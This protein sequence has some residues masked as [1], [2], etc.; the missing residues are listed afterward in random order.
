MFPGSFAACVA[1]AP[2]QP[3]GPVPPAGP[4]SSGFALPL[5]ARLSG[6]LPAGRGLLLC[7]RAGGGQTGP[8]APA[9]WSGP[10]SPRRAARPAFPLSARGAS[11]PFGPARRRRGTR[12]GS[13]A[14]RRRGHAGG[15]GG[16]AR[17]GE[18]AGPALRLE[19][20][21]P[22]RRAGGGARRGVGGGNASRARGCERA[23][24]RARPTAG[25]GEAGAERERERESEGPPPPHKG[26]RLGPPPRRAG[27]EPA[28]AGPR[29][30]AAPGGHGR[31]RAGPAAGQPQPGEGVRA[32]VRGRAGALQRCGPGRGRRGRTGRAGGPRA[33]SRGRWASGPVAPTP[34]LGVPG[35]CMYRSGVPPAPAAPDPAPPR[36]SL[37]WDFSGPAGRRRHGERGAAKEGRGVGQP[38]PCARCGALLA[39]LGPCVPAEGPSPPLS[40]QTPASRVAAEVVHSGFLRGRCPRVCSLGGRPAPTLTP[41]LRAWPLQGAAASSS[42]E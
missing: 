19:E 30:S 32:G 29:E 10:R 13:R 3:S 27:L 6:S 28:S 39:R 38:P 37:R 36:H 1:R 15:G 9:P 25:P 24:E 2:P 34:A 31:L 14:A 12:A 41:G 21:P 18:R 26:P 17:G 33:A 23:E 35:P 8:P 40:S 4:R 16:G 42:Q 22:P 11:R 7:P 20:P 5:P